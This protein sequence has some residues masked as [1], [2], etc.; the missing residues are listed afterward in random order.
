MAIAPAAQALMS[1]DAR[2]VDVY[3]A[4]RGVSYRGSSDGQ[5]ASLG[6]QSIGRVGAA[7]PT[8]RPVRTPDGEQG[9]K[10]NNGSSQ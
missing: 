9:E 5:G 6:T 2:C 1:T 7:G 10:G 3:F 4:S 8:G